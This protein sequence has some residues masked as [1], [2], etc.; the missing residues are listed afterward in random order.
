M[1]SKELIYQE[2]LEGVDQSV[3]DNDEMFSFRIKH[4]KYL[5]QKT[6]FLKITSESKKY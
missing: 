2:T 6:I 4:Y 1:I 3:R 5:Y